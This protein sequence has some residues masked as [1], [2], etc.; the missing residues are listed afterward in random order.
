M[1]ER[2]L[3][4]VYSS[5]LGS[6]LTARVGH[7]GDL[8]GGSWG[9]P[10][11]SWKPLGG[12]LGASWGLSRASWEP[13]GASWGPLGPLLGASGVLL[14]RGARN[15][16]WISPSWAPLGLLWGPVWAV[17][18]ASWTVLGPSWAVLGRSGG[19][20]WAIL[21]RSWEPLRS[22]RTVRRLRNEY[23]KNVRF[24]KGMGQFLPLGAYLG[25]KL[26]RS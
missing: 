11:A 3:V 26:E 8:L 18:G 17:W 9:P 1:D 4:D 10:G 15:F 13:L 22:S 14:E 24:T 19:A 16:N 25:D 5:F 7:L 21:G 12:P 23:A 2:P 20:S 6:L